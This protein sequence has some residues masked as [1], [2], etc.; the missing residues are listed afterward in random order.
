MSGSPLTNL[1][2]DIIKL[3]YQNDNESKL[4]FIYFKRG[5]NYERYECKYSNSQNDEEGLQIKIDNITDKYIIEL[6]HNEKNL[7]SIENIKTYICNKLK[8][9][10]KN[11][12][13]K[14]ITHIDNLINLD[15]TNIATVGSALYYVPNKVLNNKVTNNND[16]I[17]YTYDPYN[18]LFLKLEELKNLFKNIDDITAL[19]KREGEYI[20]I[21]EFAVVYLRYLLNHISP[22]K[23]YSENLIINNIE[24]L[25]IKLFIN[26]KQLDDIIGR[27]ELKK[28]IILQGPPGVGK[29]Y[30]SKMLA[31]YIT[32]DKLNG[33]FEIIQFHSRYSY[34]DFIQGYRPNENGGLK[35]VNGVFYEFC[36]RASGK[37]HEKYVFIIDEIN[38]GNISS[39]FGEA[40]SLIEVNKRNKE[41]SIKLAYSDKD[42][43]ESFYIPSNV[44]IIATMNTLDRS[45]T[46]MDYALKRRFSFFDIEPAFNEK[47]KLE[48]I[49][50]GIHRDFCNS[51][52][53]KITKINE[54]FKEPKSLNVL[55][56]GHSYFIPN[57]HIDNEKEWLR[58]IAMYE[59]KPLLLSYLYK[60][61]GK[62]DTM[63]DD[64]LKDITGEK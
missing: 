29:T 21:R 13:E 43:D 7:N 8:S 32:N 19:A 16:K 6:F 57:E 54:D 17:T 61:P 25:K 56:I 63:I 5:E 22:N 10:N 33:D 46:Q 14:F 53:N 36:K 42:V 50:K 60:D 39:I 64:L 1:L 38:R 4:D 51:I 45:I 30:I 47:F 26:E 24:N 62:I 52:C 15:Y 40:L 11:S 3:L 34:D 18:I 23:A 27:L 12:K 28:N 48:L 58:N 31:E 59:I 44:Y 2:Y 41:N 37:T 55:Q 9:D 20:N 35:K 49:N